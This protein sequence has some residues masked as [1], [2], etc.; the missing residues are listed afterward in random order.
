MNTKKYYKLFSYGRCSFQIDN[1]STVSAPGLIWNVL[2]TRVSLRCLGWCPPAQVCVPQVIH[3]P[4][5]VLIQMGGLGIE[6]EIIS[7]PCSKNVS[8][9]S[10]ISTFHSHLDI[11]KCLKLRSKTASVQKCSSCA[12]SET[13]H[14][15]NVSSMVR[16]RAMF[17]QELI[18]A[19]I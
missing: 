15:F 14:C 9:H 1:V 4:A 8:Y 6:R 2:G 19:A 17:R 13:V 5:T 11:L 10:A 3:S 16:A 7:K 12:V 18:F